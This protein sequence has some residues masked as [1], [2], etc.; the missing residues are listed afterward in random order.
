M[1]VGAN[2]ENHLRV[3]HAMAL[4]DKCWWASSWRWAASS[5]RRRVRSGEVG[6]PRRAGAGRRVLDAIV[7]TWDK[8]RDRPVRSLWRDHAVGVASYR[9]LPGGLHHSRRCSRGARS[10][11]RFPWRRLPAPRR[12]AEGPEVGFATGSSSVR[13]L[14]R[15]QASRSGSPAPVTPINRAARP[16][17]CRPGQGDLHAV[18][19]RR[20][21]EERV[22]S[23]PLLGE[24]S[25]PLALD[26]RA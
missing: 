10:S 8:T 23:A 3:I 25:L 15:W 4:R 14:L 13:G 24:S 1:E 7:A 20:G 5:S 2:G 19:S 12:V 26:A 17:H 18:H 22:W 6:D 11:S 16:F 9:Q 21:W